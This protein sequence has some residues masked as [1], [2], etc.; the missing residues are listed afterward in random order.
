MIPQCLILAFCLRFSFI[1]SLP[2][3]LDPLSPAEINKTRHIVQESYLGAIPNLTYHFVDVEEPDKNN[4]LNWL[5]SNS[6]TKEKP[7]IPRQAKVVVR[8]KGDETHELVVDLTK[9]SIVSDKIY[10]GHGYP[11]ITFSELFRASKLPLKYPKFQ[12]SITKRGLNLSE[13]SCV[14]LTVGWYG[15][16][17]T[18]RALKVVSY[19]RGGSVNVWARPIEGITVLVDVDSMKITMYNDRYL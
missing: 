15:E 6:N 8:A 2:H 5:S 13:V 4:V 9:G 14:P 3:P 17:S 11:P 19:Y 7:F 18:R 10:T 1:N 12:E 16:K